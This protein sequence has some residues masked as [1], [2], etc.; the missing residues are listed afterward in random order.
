MSLNWEAQQNP[1]ECSQPSLLRYFYSIVERADRI[2][3]ELGAR[4]INSTDHLFFMAHWQSSW[5]NKGNST[6]MQSGLFRKERKL[7]IKTA[8][9][10]KPTKSVKKCGTNKQTNRQIVNY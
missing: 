10:N 8:I 3:R 9:K 5:Q 1:F 2:A 7:C 4:M 6:Q